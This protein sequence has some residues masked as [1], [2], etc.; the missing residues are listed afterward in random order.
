MS[1]QRRWAIVAALLC[2]HV[3]A[4]SARAEVRITSSVGCEIQVELAL[5]FHGPGVSDSLVAAWKS[6]IE[7]R[8]SGLVDRT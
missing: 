1:A 7:S 3:S 8:W 6:D 4:H 5:E 2:A